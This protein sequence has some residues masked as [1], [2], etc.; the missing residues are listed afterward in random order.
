MIFVTAMTRKAMEN[1]M[2]RVLTLLQ[3]LPKGMMKDRLLIEFVKS[4]ALR[5]CAALTLGGKRCANSA[6]VASSC[7]DVHARL[8]TPM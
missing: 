3:Q 8:A 6:R 4:I 1:V 2:D 5:Q 7:C